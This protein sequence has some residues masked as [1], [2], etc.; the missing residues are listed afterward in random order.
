MADA[1]EDSSLKIDHIV[2]EPADGEAEDGDDFVTGL[3]SDDIR[4]L[5]QDL[6]GEVP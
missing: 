5:V 1:L 3:S 4:A 6:G 2:L